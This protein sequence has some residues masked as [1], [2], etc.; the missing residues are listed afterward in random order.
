MTYTTTT[1]GQEDEA[2]ADTLDG[3]SADLLPPQQND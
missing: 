3:S 2:S 1:E